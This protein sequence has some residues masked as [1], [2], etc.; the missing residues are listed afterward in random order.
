MDVLFHPGVVRRALTG[1]KSVTKEHFR[2]YLM[3]I[4][5][6]NVA[7]DHGVVLAPGRNVVM[8]VA[9]YKGPDGE[10]KDNTHAFPVFADEKDDAASAEKDEATARRAEG[11]VAS[12]S[13]RD[14]EPPARPAAR[15]TKKPIKKGF[16][17]SI[18]GLGA[19]LYPEGSAE[20]IPKPGEQ[21][22]P[23]GHI[24]ENV[25][26]NC[27]VIDSGALRG[28]DFERVTRQYA[29]T[30]RLDTSAPGVY[31]KG[32]E[33]GAKREVGIGHPKEKAASETSSR[34]TRSDAANPPEPEPEKTVVTPKEASKIT[35]VSAIT[36]P[37]ACGW[38]PAISPRSKVRYVYAIAKAIDNVRNTEYWTS[39]IPEFSR[40]NR[41]P[42]ASINRPHPSSA[43][44][45][46]PMCMFA[47]CK[48]CT[49]SE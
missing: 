16:L 12:A 8:E 10:N 5:A 30:G 35:P 9:R 43:K 20:G 24:P 27:H 38:T 48:I 42:R 23:L 14:A 31:A 7:E 49:T 33:P 39:G 11:A 34:Q 17:S 2:D 36:K 22:D 25:R 41:T 1:G 13:A 6:K 46:L 45:R 44:S 4:A 37:R 47:C 40:D 29:E 18:S 28:E 26:K 21:Y 32:S 19:E 3:D 15:R